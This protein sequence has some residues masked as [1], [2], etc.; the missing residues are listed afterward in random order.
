MDE[1]EF[2]MMTYKNII[3]VRKRKPL[4]KIIDDFI[5]VERFNYDDKIMIMK[6]LIAKIDKHIIPES[7]P[8][9]LIRG[10]DER[11]FRMVFLS[12]MG[13]SLVSRDWIR[14]LAEFIGRGKVLE[15]MSGCGSL[16]YALHNEG[17]NIIATDNFSWKEPLGTWNETKNYWCNIENI[18]AVEA[19]R[20]YG[21]QVDYIL[22][23][24]PYLTQCTAY[25]AISAMVEMNENF[26]HKCKMI[27]IGEDVDGQTTDY[28]FLDMA[29]PFPLETYCYESGIKE[30][31][32][33]DKYKNW[34]GF[35][36]KIFIAQ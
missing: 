14:L 17:V 27:Y 25:Y 24:W 22:M 1:L 33:N 32:V 31:L 16:A 9:F 19:V 36:S 35:K 8:E 12:K 20:K 28:Q 18:D 2:I 5:N 21:S 23:A 11:I 3:D 6:D 30:I 4:S 29:N 13:F 10:I 26:N 7:Y 34:K 15:V